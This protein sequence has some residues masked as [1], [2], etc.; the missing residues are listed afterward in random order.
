MVFAI[1]V[2]QV[3]AYFGK[4]IQN[5]MDVLLE[6]LEIVEINDC[7]IKKGGIETIKIMCQDIVN[8]ILECC[9]HIGDARGH[10]Q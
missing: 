2:F 8:I 5:Q 7:V 9:R 6:L 3:Q 1:F 10:N 4:S